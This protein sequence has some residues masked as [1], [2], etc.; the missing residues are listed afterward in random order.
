MFFNK[1]LPSLSF[2]IENNRDRHATL[3]D[4]FVALI[5]PT[6]MLATQKVPR[7]PLAAQ[8]LSPLATTQTHLTFLFH[9]LINLSQLLIL[10][11]MRGSGQFSR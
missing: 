2:A 3:I 11:L 7:D 8:L 4:S 6:D 9:M 5:L 10:R 1:V